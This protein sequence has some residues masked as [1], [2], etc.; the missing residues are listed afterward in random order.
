VIHHETDLDHKHYLLKREENGIVQCPL[1][2]SLGPELFYLIHAT[3]KVAGQDLD[4]INGYPATCQ[5]LCLVRYPV[6]LDS[7]T[8]TFCQ[9]N[10]MMAI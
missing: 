1:K 7:P 6:L 2:L 9:G 8:S 4:L 5:S 10:S 3:R